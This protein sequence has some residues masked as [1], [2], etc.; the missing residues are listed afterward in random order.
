ME[1]KMQN[2]E[3]VPGTSITKPKMKLVGTDSNAYSIIAKTV[4]TLRKAG[5]PSSIIEDYR[6]KSTTG[7]YD[8]LICVTMQYIDAR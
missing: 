6:I 4:R 1:L 8:N 2:E 7:D 3:C 5:I